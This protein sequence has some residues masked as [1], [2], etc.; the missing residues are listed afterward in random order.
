MCLQHQEDVFNQHLGVLQDR[1]DQLVAEGGHK[2]RWE[3]AQRDHHVMQI[4]EKYNKMQKM[5][6]EVMMQN[7][8]LK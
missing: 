7:G 3:G 5:F 2:K 6:D 4:K 8:L 1:V